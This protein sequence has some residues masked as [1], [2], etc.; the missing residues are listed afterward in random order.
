M[1][2]KLITFGKDREEARLR[3]IRAINDYHISGVETTLPFCNFVM[4][5]EAFITGNFDTHFVKH[6]FNPDSLKPEMSEEENEIAAL[7]ASIALQEY[8]NENVVAASNQESN[9]W[10]QNRKTY[11]KG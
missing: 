11:M 6:Y 1:I 4:Q 10:K 2:A 7:V 3:M 8:K 5:H 9:S